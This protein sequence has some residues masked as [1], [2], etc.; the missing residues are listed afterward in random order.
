MGTRRNQGQSGPIRIDA[1][2]GDSKTYG[3]RNAKRDTKGNIV[4]GIGP[5][6][7]PFGESD[8][9]RSMFSIDGPQQGGTQA[10]PEGSQLLA[11]RQGL[12]SDMQSAGAGGITPEMEQRAQSMGIAPSSFRRI[13]STLGP[14][15]TAAA[16]APAT[17]TIPQPPATRNP[18]IPQTATGGGQ[19]VGMAPFR[20]GTDQPGLTPQIAANTPGAIPTPAAGQP[21]INRLTGK[22]IGYDPS[23]APKTGSALA[24]SNIQKMGVAG[25]VKDYQARSDAAKSVKAQSKW[26]QASAMPTAGKA[27][28]PITGG[29]PDF[30][31]VAGLPALKNPTAA[32]FAVAPVANPVPVGA[33]PPPASQFAALT[34]AKPADPAPAALPAPPPSLTPSAPSG[35]MR[36]K[37]PVQFSASPQALQKD[38]A[39]QRQ[40][41]TPLRAQAKAMANNAITVPKMLEGTG[42][43]ATL[44][45]LQ[46]RY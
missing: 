31:A 27:L 42:G 20:P 36:D 10:A 21:R 9:N 38:E 3:I 40:K 18:A 45:A 16:P 15:Q 33:P 6:G 32:S 30:R 8:P 5:D 26:K 43:G 13:A 17:A 29:K 28:A 19:Q 2:V 25:A 41:N 24:E 14:P 11:G 35:R 37:N 34:Q 22:P 1:R 12:Y 4:G 7:V 44:R 39:A 46:R 23:M